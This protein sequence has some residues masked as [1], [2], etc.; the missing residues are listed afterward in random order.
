MDQL[1]WG[2]I[3]EPEALREGKR[4]LLYGLHCGQNIFLV[5][6]YP[7]DA[8]DNKSLREFSLKEQLL[9]ILLFYLSIR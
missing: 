6:C 8:W 4:I 2:L 7:V 1:R 9:Y 5:D 3:M